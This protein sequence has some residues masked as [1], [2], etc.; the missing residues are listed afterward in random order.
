MFTVFVS[1]VILIAKIKPLWGEVFEGFLPSKTIGENANA[2]YT[3]IGI[4]GA[5]VM[6]HAL[7]LGSSLATQNR[8]GSNFL[9]TISGN[10]ISDDEEDPEELEVAREARSQE[11]RIRKRI[12]HWLGTIISAERIGGS[13]EEDGMIDRLRFIQ[14]HLKNAVVDIGNFS[15]SDRS[16][17]EYSN[18]LS[19]QFQVF[20]ASL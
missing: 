3:S 17:E 14:V 13:L 11:R 2:L 16:L 9:V 5:T 4:I 19:F 10:H 8:V 18:D 6:P 15:N 1:F 12:G 20:W 7:F